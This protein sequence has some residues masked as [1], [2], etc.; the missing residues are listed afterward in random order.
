MLVQ[1]IDYLKGIKEVDVY[2]NFDDGKSFDPIE[3]L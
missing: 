3:I 2:L 1:Q